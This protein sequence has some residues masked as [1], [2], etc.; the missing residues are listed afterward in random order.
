L[1]EILQLVAIK[2]KKILLE[3]RN[4]ESFYSII[5]SLLQTTTK[6]L[7]QLSG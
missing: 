3:G 5:L 7:F 2:L 4:D 6:G 1:L